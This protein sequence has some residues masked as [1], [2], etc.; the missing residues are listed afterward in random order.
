M[1]TEPSIRPRPP[2]P[3]SVSEEAQQFLAAEARTTAP[4]P[5]LDDLA[6]WERH[7]A[8]GDVDIA[9]V[10]TFVARADG[11]EDGPESPVYLY[12]HGGAL[13][14]GGGEACR[15]MASADA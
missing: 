1:S 14:L 7:V 3:S 2:V 12:V 15:L 5:A 10:R 13:V 9:G 4:P 8:E 6:G 11:V